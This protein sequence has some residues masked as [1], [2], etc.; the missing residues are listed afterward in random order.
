MVFVLQYI[1]AEFRHTHFWYGVSKKVFE[2]K[3]IFCKMY[4]EIWAFDGIFC[5]GK[6]IKK[7]IYHKS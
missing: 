6:Q 4:I 3:I 1:A 2:E 5:C 7:F